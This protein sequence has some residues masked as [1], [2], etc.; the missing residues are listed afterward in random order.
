MRDEYWTDSIVRDG[1]WD[2]A[3]CLEVLIE[4]SVYINPQHYI[5][6]GPL[7]NLRG[8]VAKAV[9]TLM[10]THGYGWELENH[11]NTP[12]NHRPG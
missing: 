7:E 2:K 10:F 3:A 8:S 12:F 4:H 9:S 11:G 5:I 1:S 6:T